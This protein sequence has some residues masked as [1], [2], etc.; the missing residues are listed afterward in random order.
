RPETLVPYVYCL[1]NPIK[2]IDLFGLYTGDGAVVPIDNY[3]DTVILPN[4]E[5]EKL[6]DLKFA[7]LGYVSIRDI[8]DI[9]RR[10]GGYAANTANVEWNQDKREVA[11]FFTSTPK[12]NRMITFSYSMYA[13]SAWTY[14]IDP[15]GNKHLLDSQ[16]GYFYVLTCDSK[17]YVDLK[18]FA[19]AAGFGIGLRFY[20]RGTIGANGLLPTSEYEPNFD[21][22]AWRGGSEK[23]PALDGDIMWTTNCYAYALDLK[24]NPF[25]KGEQLFDPDSPQPGSLST[26]KYTQNSSVTKPGDVLDVK[27][28]FGAARK[29]AWALGNDFARSDKWEKA[30]AGMYKVALALGTYRKKPDY[31]WYRQDDTGYWSHKPNE[32]LPTDLDW[33]RNRITDPE[34][35]IRKTEGGGDYTT[36]FDSYYITGKPR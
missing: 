13:G 7:Y 15:R 35:A 5:K 29:D 20:I 32:M 36:G 18:T 1:D 6:S 34:T 30:P 16:N 24:H 12:Y 10:S 33:N 3:S 23:Y 27:V 28:I 21:V 26:G 19:K 11:G 17:T 31:H 8:F 4:G 9:L 2:Y 22:V 14:M 25:E